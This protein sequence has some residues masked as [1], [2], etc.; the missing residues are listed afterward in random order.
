[1][2]KFAWDKS[3]ICCGCGE[4]FKE[5]EAYRFY[6]KTCICS[7]CSCELPKVEATGCFQ[8]IKNLQFVI[9]PFYYKDLYRNIFL[10]FKFSGDYAAGKILGMLSAEY[11]AAVE[12]LSEFDYISVIPISK[13]RMNERGYN[14]SQILAEF[15]AEELNIE[16]RNVLKR[17][18][19]RTAQSNL[20]GYE[21]IVNIRDV[22]AV[23]ENVENKKIL[24][25]DDVFTTGNT[26]E[27]CAKTLKENGASCIGGIACAYVFRDY[28]KN[29]EAYAVIKHT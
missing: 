28:S 10:K 23:T 3:Y 19:H 2:F 20:S 16:I 25:F 1:M 17:T 7:R 9:S 5:N 6:K 24:I 26:M 21:R 4:R 29:H 11:F 22:F 27:E 12:D 14:Q 15:I 13:E 8:G 18:E